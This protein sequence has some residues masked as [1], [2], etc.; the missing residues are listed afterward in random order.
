VVKALYLEF[1]FGDY[2]WPL[3][4]NSGANEVII[5]LETLTRQ[6]LDQLK[7]CGFKMGISIDSFASRCPAD[8]QATNELKNKLK[9]ALDWKPQRIWLDGFRFGGYWET[10]GNKI[11]NIHEPCGWCKNKKRSDILI[12]VASSI[13]EILPWQLPLG[14]FAVPFKKEEKSEVVEILGQDHF[15]LSQLFDFISPMIYHRMIGKSVSYISEYIS[16]LKSM[17]GNTVIP[18]LQ[19][20]DMPDNLPDQL[21][22]KEMTKAFQEAVKPPSVGVAW[23]SW[24]GAAEK[25]K[26]EIISKIFNST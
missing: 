15:F 18:I 20:K 4:K 13:R 14:Y 17:T 24:D 25:K 11:K 5:P 2:D 16:Y 19:T 7:D 1:K 8:P 9:Q 26:A 10:K 23:F 3:L 12:S 6:R 21:S 22:G